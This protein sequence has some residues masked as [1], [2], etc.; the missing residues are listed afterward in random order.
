[1][2]RLRSLATLA[3]ICVCGAQSSIA[4][5]FVWNRVDAS[6]FTISAGI[7]P[8]TDGDQES[9]WS[10]TG[11]AHAVKTLNRTIPGLGTSYVVAQSWLEPNTDGQAEAALLATID[12]QCLATG[13]VGNDGWGYQE[14]SS[15]ISA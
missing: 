14:F 6:F 10:S 12:N 7:D 8:L 4:G 3:V 11:D 1:M 9:D 5:D 2:G 13:D 15:R